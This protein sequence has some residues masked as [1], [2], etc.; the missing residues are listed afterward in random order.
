MR[1]RKACSSFRWAFE[2]GNFQKDVLLGDLLLSNCGVINITLERT[3][4]Y[5]SMFPAAV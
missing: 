3:S 2:R 4:K 5:Q 1:Y